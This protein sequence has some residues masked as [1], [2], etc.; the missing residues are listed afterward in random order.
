MNQQIAQAA[1][2]AAAAEQK[3]RLLASEGA[4]ARPDEPLTLSSLSR[5]GSP[6]SV[7][8]LSVDSEVNPAF[9]MEPLIRSSLTGADFYGVPAN[10]AAKVVVLSSQELM[11]VM[12]QDAFGSELQKSL[13]LVSPALMGGVDWFLPEGR[14]LL[15]KSAGT[16]C[17]LLVVVLSARARKM[18]LPF[19]QLPALITSV[20]QKSPAAI[21]V[22]QGLLA[23]E[24][25][26]LP[27]FFGLLLNV[28]ACEPD[29]GFASAY[30][31]SPAAGTFLAGVNVSPR[32]ENIRMTASGQIERASYP[33]Y[34]RDA[35]TREMVKLREQGR[36]L[37]FIGKE[38]G[39][40]RATVLRRLQKLP[41]GHRHD[42]GE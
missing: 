36:T 19:D 39:V 34:A 29:E 28:Q 22:F 14:A 30:M 12:L 11:H 6:G 16:N 37:E 27:N 26:Q 32:V 1:T 5:L 9:V 42:R 20:R 35:E 23:D 24:V 18:Q 40:D 31:A 3:P 13:K 21:L 38:F 8:A 2:N 25:K 41:Y 10:K 17:G 7:G 33:S 15:E 4:T